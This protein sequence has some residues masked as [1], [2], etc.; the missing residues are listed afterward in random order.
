MAGLDQYVVLLLHCNGADAS[1]TFVDNSNSNHTVTANGNAQVDT[2][3]SKF[4]GASAYF[5][6]TGDYLSAGDSDNWQL[7]AGSDSNSWTI[8]FWVRF[9]GDPGAND[10]GFVQQRVDNDNF[11]SIQVSNGNELN[12]RVRS[13]GSNIVDI[14]QSWNPADATW[15]HVAVVKNGATGYMFF[16]DGTQIGSTT[17]D[18]STIPN[19]VGGIRIGSVLGT[20]GSEASEPMWVDELRISKGIARWTTN[21]TPPVAPYNRPPFAPIFFEEYAPG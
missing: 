11:W 2:A 14:N 19:F 10:A 13:G 5:D 15:Y 8:D 9:N 20:S 21:F 18:T 6:G 3:Q 16:I 1:T 17:T 7:D 12:F 4:G